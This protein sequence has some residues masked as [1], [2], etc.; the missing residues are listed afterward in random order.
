MRASF[1]FGASI[2][3]TGYVDRLMA[4]IDPRGHH[5]IILGRGRCADLVDCSAFADNR[6][7]LNHSV[8]DIAT[9]VAEPFDIVMSQRDPGTPAM[10]NEKLTADG[11]VIAQYNVDLTTTPWQIIEQTSR[12]ASLLAY[13]DANGNLLLAQLGTD[14]AS[15]GFAQRV[16]V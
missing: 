1:M 13:E 6:Q 7:F 10:A 4:S 5:I 11:Q 2:V 14:A 9:A 16:N 8:L 12:Y 3:V 15:S